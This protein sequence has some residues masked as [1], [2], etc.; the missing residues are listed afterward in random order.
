MRNFEVSFACGKTDNYPIYFGNGCLEDALKELDLDSYSKIALVVDEKVYGLWKERL[1]AVRS[2]VVVQIEAKEEAKSLDTVSRVT[3]EF[4]KNK[5][6][7]H[8]LVINIGG[9]LTT[10]LGGFA[11]SIYMRGIDFIHVPTSLLAQVDAGVGGKVGV[12]FADTKNLLGVFR[13]PRAVIM[14][15]SFLK[16]LSS[17]E[18]AS[19][20]GELIK[21]A[22]IK[23][24][25][26]YEILEDVS[27]TILD[28]DEDEIIARS[29]KV[30]AEVVSADEK[31]AG[32]RKILNFGHT[33]GHAVEILSHGG[34][35]HGEAVSIGMVVAAN[36]SKKE[37]YLTNV[38]FSEIKDLL[39]R[40]NLPITFSYRGDLQ[41]I[42]KKMLSD[43]KN[44]AGVLKWVLL[45]KIGE[46][47][48]DV[49]IENE[50]V[51]T[52]INEVMD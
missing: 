10:D 1:N 41:D 5:L 45:K 17:R 25:G 7:R 19:G 49:E 4:F 22:L 43:K 46:A 50:A 20:Y 6:D 26:L 37:G 16:T 13:Q 33:F 34:L 32:L 52:A 47:I 44:N 14:D 18:R 28:F 40:Y 39:K 29:C 48:Y 3:E 9:G 2:S 31:E 42:F 21:H 11:A 38:E 36:L 12:N 8:S 30:K 35:L 51:M 15:S 23:D 24:R 27:T